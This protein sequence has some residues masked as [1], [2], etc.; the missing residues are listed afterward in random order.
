MPPVS[1]DVLPAAGVEQNLVSLPKSQV[2]ESFANREPDMITY[3]YTVLTPDV[4]QQHR[5]NRSPFPTLLCAVTNQLGTE[6]HP[7]PIEVFEYLPHLCIRI[8]SAK[9]ISLAFISIHNLLGDS[10]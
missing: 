9:E 3:Q 6:C 7:S 1:F 10:A 8:Y 4:S 2:F 5:A